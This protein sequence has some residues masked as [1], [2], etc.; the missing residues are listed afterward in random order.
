[1]GKLDTIIVIIII[2]ISSIISIII[3]FTNTISE[4]G[5]AVAYFHVELLPKA[6]TVRLFLS[7]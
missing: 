2:I 7:V 3:A 6:D 4:A 5:S 1:M